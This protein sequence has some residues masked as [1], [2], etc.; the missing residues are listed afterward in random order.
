MIM[1]IPYVV[2][3]LEKQD[4]KLNN[5]NEIVDLSLEKALKELKKE[6]KDD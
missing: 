6:N 5:L 3:S 1:G 4:G 2:N